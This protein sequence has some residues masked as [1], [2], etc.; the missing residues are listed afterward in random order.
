MSA[1][2]CFENVRFQYDKE[3]WREQ[4]DSQVSMPDTHRLKNSR[5]GYLWAP[6]CWHLYSVCDFNQSSRLKSLKTCRNPSCPTLSNALN[7][8]EL[9]WT[10]FRSQHTNNCIS[11][12]MIIKCNRGDP[13]ETP[14]GLYRGPPRTQYN[15]HYGHIRYYKSKL[16][17]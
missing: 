6:H 5:S 2:I 17:I 9:N 12:N 7:W 15:V 1:V 10:L 11:I 3:H 4:V 13:L 8:I 14:G 16:N